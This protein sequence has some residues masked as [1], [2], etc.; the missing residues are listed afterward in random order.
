MAVLATG[1]AEDRHARWYEALRRAC[2]V[3]WVVD[4]PRAE[5]AIARCLLDALPEPGMLDPPASSRAVGDGSTDPFGA[6]LAK[7]AAHVS[8]YLAAGVAGDLDLPLCGHG[9]T[10]KNDDGSTRLEDSTATAVRRIAARVAGHEIRSDWLTWL[11]AR[12]VGDLVKDT[13]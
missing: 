11:W 12:A 10:V 4:G 6:A 1:A 8:A 7:A 2:G 9:E 13:M 5:E 3:P